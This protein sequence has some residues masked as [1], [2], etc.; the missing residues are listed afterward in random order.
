MKLESLLVSNDTEIL[1]VLKPIFEKLL[2]SV[3]VS[4]TA[5]PV[6][7]ILL[8]K[9]FDGV[10]VDCDDVPGAIGILHEL[11]NTPS[12]KSSVAFAIL[13]GKTTTQEA[14]Q[15]GANF[16]L[17]KPIAP[18]NASRCFNAALNV[19][20]RERRRYFRFPIEMS[21]SIAFGPDTRLKATSTNISE[22]GM[23]VRFRDPLPKRGIS[24]IEFT[25]PGTTAA[26]DTKAEIAWSDGL[27]RA[28]V[29]FVDLPQD[30]KFMLE[31][32]L[33]ERM[34]KEPVPPVEIP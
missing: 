34:E 19:M 21:V 14:F 23:A 33:G 4:Q 16:V 11:R 3:Q 31:N 5:R 25:L 28:G 30:S 20:L 9:K 12:N 10:I 8:K 24:N 2:I 15:Q 26:F 17:Q 7:D 32:W 6:V 1:Q 18:L 29:R 27:G 13:N 22:G